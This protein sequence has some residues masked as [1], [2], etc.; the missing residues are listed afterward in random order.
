M[1]LEYFGFQREPF[2]ATPDTR[3]LFP[4]HTHRE[5]L[6]SLKYSFQSNRGFTAM[7][8]P[9]GMGKTTLLFRFLEDIRETARSVFL[10]NIS[11]DCEPRDFLGYI[12]RDMGIVPGQS[13]SEMHQQLSTAVV[14][15]NQA[16]RKFVVVIDE[17]QN[18]SEAVM[19]RVR[20]LSNFETARGKLMQIVLSGQPQLSDKLM[21]ASLIQLRQ[22]ISTI[23]RIDPLSADETVS[24]INYRLTQAGYEGDQLFAKDALTLISKAGQGTPRIINTLCFNSLSLCRALNSKQVERSMVSEVI[25]DLNLPMSSGEPIFTHADAAVEQPH[26]PENGSQLHSSLKRWGPASGLLLAICTL[27]VIGI[28]EHRTHQSHKSGDEH[29]L[30]QD[31]VPASVSGQAGASTG[32]ATSREPD[33]NAPFEIAVAPNQTIQEI[34]VQYL[35]AFNP[36]SLHQIQVL[37]PELKDPNF[38]VVGQN[39]WLPGPPPTSAAKN[40]RPPTDARILP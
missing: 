17:A 5:A 36:Q 26:A 30:G 32:L 35:G 39:L 19:E 28:M 16:G 7:I 1:Q 11:A 33:P 14:K 23:C 34:A 37:N 4:S 10:F 9:P 13:S 27:G 12:L 3:Y 29:S 31:A 40:T 6:A 38:I 22:R 18:L 15:E 21:Q 25:A 24:Y 8:A 2:G 20:L